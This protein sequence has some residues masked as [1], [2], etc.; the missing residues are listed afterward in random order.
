MTLKAVLTLDEYDG[1]DEAVQGLYRQ[2]QTK[3]AW[4]LDLDGVQEHPAVKGLKNTLDRFR[5]IAPDAKAMKAIKDNHD[6]LTEA[7]EGL[8]PEDTRS[9]LERLTDLEEGDGTGDK[10]DVKALIEAAEAK[11]QRKHDKELAKRDEAITGLTGERDEITGKFTSGMIERELDAGLLHINSTEELREGA[12]AY[13]EKRYAPKVDRSE[14][15]NGKAVFRGVIRSDLGEESIP[16]FFER[17]QTLDEAL[18]YLPASGNVGTGSKTA[19]G[20]PR[21]R[22]TNPWSKEHWNV[23]EQGR[24]VKDNRGAAK[25]MAAAHG[26]EISGE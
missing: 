20:G 7:W 18:P 2:N 19:D 6:A 23:T 13:I 11:L 10:P 3:D 12:K 1:V 24:I 14:D 5:E 22:K 8:D 17:W 26:H 9:A 4:I 25:T 16:D 15:D 21:S